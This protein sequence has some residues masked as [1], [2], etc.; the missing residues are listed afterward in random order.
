M[1]MRLFLLSYHGR[2]L[3]IEL[4]D[5]DDEPG[6]LQSLSAVAENLDFGT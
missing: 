4:D 3:V 6:T 2:V 1:T 5:I